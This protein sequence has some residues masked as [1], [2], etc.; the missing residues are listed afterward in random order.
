MN[1]TSTASTATPDRSTSA[2]AYNA[3]GKAHKTQ[4]DQV[5]DIVVA[6]MRRGATDMTAREIRAELDDLEGYVH[7][8]GTIAARVNNLIAQGR[9]VRLDVPRP[10]LDKA[11]RQIGR[12]SARPVAVVASQVRMF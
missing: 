7:Q 10:S 1:L 4:C 8:D 12:A 2:Q 9:L 5:L 11:G 6:A 3:L